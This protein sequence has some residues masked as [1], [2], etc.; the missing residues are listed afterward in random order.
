MPLHTLDILDED[1]DVLQKAATELDLPLSAFIEILVK[2]DA[3]QLRDESQ[4]P[5]EGE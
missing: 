4:K 3:A 5:Q 2:E 1:L